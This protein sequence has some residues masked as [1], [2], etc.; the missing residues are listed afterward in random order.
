M[1]LWAE[2]LKERE[3]IETIEALDGFATYKLFPDT[4]ECYIIDV[5]TKKEARKSGLAAGLADQITEIAKN[6]GCTI[7][8]GTV[9]PRLPS[10]TTSVMVL[11]S[12]GMRLLRAEPSKLVFMKEI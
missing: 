1:S 8:T 6:H 2:Y 9:D 10:A 4:K 7:L 3:G 11:V 12:Y 5:Y